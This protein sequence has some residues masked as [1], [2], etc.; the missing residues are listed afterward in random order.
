M[1][2]RSSAA[3]ALAVLKLRAAAAAATLSKACWRS[4][5]ECEQHMLVC[6]QLCLAQQY[7]LRLECS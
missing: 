2:V 4:A 6:T 3:R 1:I 5:G 7:G